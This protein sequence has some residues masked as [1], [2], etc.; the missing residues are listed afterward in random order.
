MT[1][2]YDAFIAVMLHQE[3]EK[4]F[5]LIGKE[6]IAV[7]VIGDFNL[8]VHR[9]PTPSKDVSTSHQEM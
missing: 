6:K 7:A 4:I 3:L 2:L 8:H 1:S 5:N 9:R